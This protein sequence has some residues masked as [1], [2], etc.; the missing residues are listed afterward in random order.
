MTRLHVAVVGE[1]PTV[2][3][4][5]GFTGSGT[6]MAPLTERLARSRRVVAVDLVGHGRSPIP[7]DPAAYTVDAMAV[8]VA[9]VIGDAPAPV[10]GYSMGGRVALTLAC[11]RPSVVTSLVLIGATPGIAEPAA[12]AERRTSD[13]AL[14][15]SIETDG[16]EAFVDR[17]MANPLF[18]SQDALGE[19]FLAEARAQRLAADPR[20][21]AR[22]L[23]G[24]GTGAMTPLHDRLPTCTVPTVLVVGELDAKF[25]AIAASMALPDARVE[26]V[27]GVGHAAHLEAPDRVADIVAGHTA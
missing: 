20:G 6:A 11:R 4:L 23:R 8:D 19:A 27:A 21:L 25:R 3:V 16:L 17:W 1:G 15:A 7:D 5:H 10:V 18:V 2:V 26:V 13:E 24:G 9:E 12:R 14:A 22:S